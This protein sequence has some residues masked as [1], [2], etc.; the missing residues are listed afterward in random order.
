MIAA[1][2]TDMNKDQGGRRGL[3]V[4]LV[5]YY[6]A[7]IYLVPSTAK[8]AR[9]SFT[10][11]ALVVPIWLYI[12]ANWRYIFRGYSAVSVLFA[13]FALLA[14][15][16]GAFRGD[17]PLAYNAAF[18][19]AAAIVVL[20]SRAYLTVTEL[21][22]IFLGCVFGSI[23]VAANGATEYRFLPD[24][25]LDN[26]NSVMDFRISLFRVPAESAMF[27]LLLLIVNIA[28]GNQ[29]RPWSRVVAMW[30]AMYFLV[31]SGVRG[32]ALT[33]MVVVP[34]CVAVMLP[35]YSAQ[36]RRQV[37]AALAAGAVTIFALPYF[38]A[39][40]T[41]FW[42]NYV[43]RTEACKFQL[44]YVLPTPPAKQEPAA[45]P[46]VAKNAQFMDWINRTLNRHCAIRYQLFSFAHSPLGSKNLQPASD[47]ELTSL[48]CPA[49]EL[50]DYCISCSF[51]SY[52]LA[53][54]GVAAVA[55]LLGFAAM[56]VL[57]ARRRQPIL[58]L[59]LMGFGLVSL[60]W[61]VMYVPYNFIFLLMMAMPAI[62]AAHG[63]GREKA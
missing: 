7:A 36:T 21:N 29:L 9:F 33:A 42:K 1:N 37:L 40:G 15:A 12:A 16:T 25:S 63:E 5:L 30:G 47:E 18:L 46:A 4:A 28:Y 11:L 51:F 23:A 62:A 56:I 52:W 13:A 8:V 53:R 2:V 41:N 17:L 26:C 39:N 38:L 58:A 24:F 14:G 34:A 45:A 10:Y 3:F 54:G 35:R 50:G 43:L 6:I 55:M 27:S 44:L 32:I 59:T 61:G 60:S 20:N 31:F 48:G 22:W 49:G 57:A 19:A